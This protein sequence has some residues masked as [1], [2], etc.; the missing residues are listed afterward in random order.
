MP[1]DAPVPHPLEILLMDTNCLRS[2]IRSSWSV[3]AWASFATAVSSQ[4]EHLNAPFQG[5]PSSVAEFW[6]VPGTTD[7]FYQADESLDASETQ[8]VYR[9]ALDGAGSSSVAADPSTWLG[10]H[11]VAAVA[12]DGDHIV[13]QRFSDHGADH[14]VVTLLSWE[15]ATWIDLVDVPFFPDPPDD[16]VVRVS[17]DGAQVVFMV[18]E[19]T[20]SPS[21]LYS[22]PI[23]GSS[24]AKLLD[25]PVPNFAL[26]S[27]HLRAVYRA[28]NAESKLELRSVLLDDSQP[29]VT[30]NAPLPVNG[31]VSVFAI[32]PDVNRVVYRANQLQAGVNELFLV[33]VDGSA[34]PVRLNGS[35]VS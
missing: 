8:R 12:P 18:P 28:E 32:T 22:V 13:T 2:L 20:S 21:R 5:N 23:D 27:A 31:S 16:F 3:L 29:P 7:V 35:L 6:T 17:P 9:A 26:S 4:N 10:I 24:P 34:P 11:S 1:R 19:T 33:P 30:L 15:G 14:Y 25:T